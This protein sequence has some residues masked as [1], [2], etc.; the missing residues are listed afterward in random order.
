MLVNVN[1]IN[2][3]GYGKILSHQ[4]SSHFRGRNKLIQKSD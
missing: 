2:N 3:L 4:M 1:N